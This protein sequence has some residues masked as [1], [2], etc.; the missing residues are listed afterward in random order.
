MP[1]IKKLLALSSLSIVGTAKNTGKTATLNYVLQ[2]IAS[3]APDKVVGL[4]SIGL[5][6][7]RRDQVTQTEKPE[8]TLS[9]GTLFVTAEHYYRQ[10]QLSAEVLGVERVYTTST[11]RLIYARARGEGKVLIAGPPT[12]QGLRK[13]V[14]VM[15]RDGADLS[16]IDGALSRKSLASPAVADGLILATGA[17]FSAQPERLIQLTK[18]LV[19]QIELPEFSDLLL[20]SRLEEVT[21]GIRL[22]VGDEVLDPGYASALLPQFWEDGRWQLLEGLIFVSGAVHDNLLER[23]RQAKGCRGLIVRDFTRLFV[24]GQAVRSLLASGKKLYTLRRADLVA[25]TFNP[26]APTGFRMPSEE[27]CE[28]LSEALEVPVYDIMRCSDEIS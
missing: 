20:A 21:H 26:V 10:K 5:E 25:V 18:E 23:I 3:Q 13:V 8:I 7:E 9:K 16:I 12:T 4:T 22:V 6:G 19:Q 1:F 24:S 14:E 2:R 27:M 28:R 17:A 11:G 15:Q